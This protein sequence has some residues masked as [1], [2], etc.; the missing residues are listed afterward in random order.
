M[1]GEA[2]LLV[3]RLRRAASG[4][5][6]RLADALCGAGLFLIAVLVSSS[7]KA[8][9]QDPMLFHDQGG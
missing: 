3:T 5:K 7:A 4:T 9:G 1:V 6:R 2:S 8:Q